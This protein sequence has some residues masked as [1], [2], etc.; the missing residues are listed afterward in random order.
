MQTFQHDDI[1]II[2]MTAPSHGNSYYRI[3]TLLEKLTRSLRHAYTQENVWGQIDVAMIEFLQ[4]IL[5]LN[6]WGGAI[7]ALQVLFTVSHFIFE[8]TIT[9]HGS[10]KHIL[11]QSTKGD[12][13]FSRRESSPFC[14]ESTI[15]LASDVVIRSSSI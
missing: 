12:W 14:S 5:P 4:I 3:V 15:K 8:A 1:E 9:P 6:F 13:T 7:H 11:N 2:K 10:I